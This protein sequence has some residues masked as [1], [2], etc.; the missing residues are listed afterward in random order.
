MESG[1]HRISSPLHLNIPSSLSPNHSYMSPKSTLSPSK[2]KHNGKWIL[3]FLVWVLIYNL[4]TD[5]VFGEH[6]Q[7]MPI[8]RLSTIYINS[9][10]AL[11]NINV[12]VIGMLIEW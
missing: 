1:F 7:L 8:N 5:I 4:N 12:T 11:A 3:L 9:D 6:L 10:E 2:S